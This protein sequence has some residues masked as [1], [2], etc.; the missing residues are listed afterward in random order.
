MAGC[1]F[2][3]ERKGRAFPHTTRRSPFLLVNLPSD[4]YGS[5]KIKEQRALVV[6]LRSGKADGL[7]WHDLEMPAKGPGVDRAVCAAAFLPDGK[8]LFRP[9]LGGADA[10]RL[11]ASV[12]KEQGRFRIAHRCEH[13]VI[14]QYHSSLVKRDIHPAASLLRWPSV[15]FFPVSYDDHSFLEPPLE[16]LQQ[17]YH[18]RNSVLCVKY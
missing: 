15:K 11:I 9:G 3:N 4:R 16:I 8:R 17:A 18:Q 2:M 14:D 12:V 13:S 5:I 10:D 7:E 6:D 1:E